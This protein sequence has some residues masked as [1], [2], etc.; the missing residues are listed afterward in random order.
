MTAISPFQMFSPIHL[1]WLYR[2][3]EK[4]LDVTAADLASIEAHRPEAVE[5][6]LFAD[7]R[8]RADSGNL[9]R[10]RGRK[11]IWTR[12]FGRLI[13]AAVLIDQE[14]ETIWADRRAGL[15]VRM[16]GDE[17]PIHEAAENVARELGYGTGRSLLN[18]LSRHAPKKSGKEKPAAA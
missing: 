15:R 13:C 5:D 11:P 17:S 18:L 14:V 1:A 10:R 3:H 9:C 2:C 7:Y 16:R 8:S 4:G 12:G 6:P